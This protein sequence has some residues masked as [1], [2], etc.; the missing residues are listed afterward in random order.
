MKT[1]K[2]HT[3]LYCAGLLAWAW[4]GAEKVTNKQ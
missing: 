2:K 1:K 3:E 4:A